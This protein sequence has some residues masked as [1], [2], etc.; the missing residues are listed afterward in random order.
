MEIRTGDCLST[1][2][3]HIAFNGDLGSTFATGFDS[4]FLGLGQQ[5]VIL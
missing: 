2:S 3:S 5:Y 1:Q 4:V